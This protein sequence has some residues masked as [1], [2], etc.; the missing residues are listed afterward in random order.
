MSYPWGAFD[1]NLK[2]VGRLFQVL[3]LCLGLFSHQGCLENEDRRPLEYEDLLETEDLENE[4]EE[5]E[6]TK[7]HSKTNES[8]NSLKSMGSC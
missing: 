5:L 6:K 4:T 1:L 7:T 2:K 3:P 8:P